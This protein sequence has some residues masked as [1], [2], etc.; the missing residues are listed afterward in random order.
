MLR[1]IISE[2]YDWLEMPCFNHRNPPLLFVLNLF[3]STNIDRF[4]YQI[5]FFS[6]R[7]GAD[8]TF[9]KVSMRYI[10]RCINLCIGSAYEIYGTLD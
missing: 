8:F 7:N 10:V 1:F 3:G 2:F 9:E 5:F 6:L 4:V